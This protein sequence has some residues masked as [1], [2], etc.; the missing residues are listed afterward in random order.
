[1]T[2]PYDSVSKHTTDKCNKEAG[3]EFLK[4]YNTFVAQS[5]RK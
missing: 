2:A 3:D 1:M 4:K 5:T